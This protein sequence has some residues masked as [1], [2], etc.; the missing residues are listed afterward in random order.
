[1]LDKTITLGYYSSSNQN[2]GVQSMNGIG[3]RLRRIR[4]DLR[5]NQIE[6]SA[7]L[8]LS[9]TAL[10][11]CERDLSF[12]NKKMLHILAT[13]FNISMDYLLCNRGTVF[14]NNA[15]QTLDGQKLNL[16]KEMEEMLFLM[17]QSP[18]VHHSI[19]SFLQR[20]KISN[21]ELI[22]KQLAQNTKKPNNS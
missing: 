11:K 18:L 5:L 7:K 9:R 1:V 8:G 4:E 3:S 16:D 6:F 20:F 2:N 12:P 19:M 21:Q 10:G 14:Y 17:T 22:E 15:I 13:Q